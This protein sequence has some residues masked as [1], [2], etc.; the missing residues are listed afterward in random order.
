MIG[1]SH[2]ENHAPMSVVSVLTSESWM[3]NRNDDKAAATVSANE[4]TSLSALIAYVAYNSG[5]HEFRVERRLAD[6]FNIQNVSRLPAALFD[7]A[8]RY[9]VDGMAQAAA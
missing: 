1:R 4:L 3:Q 5:E 2:N 6:R 8:I 9:L 7:T